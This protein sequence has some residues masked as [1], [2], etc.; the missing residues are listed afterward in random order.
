VASSAEG[1]RPDPLD[2]ARFDALACD[3]DGVLTP[4]EAVHAAA[5]KQVFDELLALRAAG[6]PYEPFDAEADYAAY[7]DGKPRED[8]AR[9][10]LA[11]RGLELPDGSPDDPPGLGTVAALTRRKDRL[12]EEVL[13]SQGVAPYPGAVELLEAARARGLKVAVVSSSRHAR[14]VLAA[15]R[16]DGLVDAVVDGT[17]A[18]A[19][20]LAGKPAPDLYLAAARALCVEPA[21]AVVLEDARA[22]VAAGRAGGFGL[23]IGV[24][25]LGQADELASA[26]ADL[27]VR[28]LRELLP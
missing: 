18:L 22:G 24:D 6:G 15:A 14:Q 21:R 19:E 16:L 17:T 7:V 20:G 2:P 25:R 5:W 3:L 28:D 26:G 23:V 11:A 1:V 13:A 12:V 27:V 10:F 8:G 4:T 9:A